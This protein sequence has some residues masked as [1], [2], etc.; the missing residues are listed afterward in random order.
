MYGWDYSTATW[1]QLAYKATTGE[2]DYTDTYTVPVTYFET[3]RYL[4][5]VYFAGRANLPCRLHDINVSYFAP[6][7][8]PN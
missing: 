7:P 1:K 6:N 8:M 4:F 5:S 2:S 3:D